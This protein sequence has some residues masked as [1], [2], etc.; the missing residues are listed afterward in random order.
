MSKIEALIA[1]KQNILN[2]KQTLL[3]KHEA[4]IADI[5]S[6][7]GHLDVDI[8]ALHQGMQAVADAYDQVHSLAQ[9]EF[10]KRVR[11]DAQSAGK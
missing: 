8:D 1:F 11:L 10:H 5:E 6:K 9:S 4:E 2:K 3:E 7:A